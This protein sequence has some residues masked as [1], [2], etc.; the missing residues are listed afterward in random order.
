MHYCSVIMRAMASHISMFC[1]TV[2]S[3]AD[4]RKH[5]SFPFDDVIMILWTMGTAFVM[6]KAG[7]KDRD[8]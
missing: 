2:G 6:Q 4:Q 1:S 8:K 3:S 7:I 5:E